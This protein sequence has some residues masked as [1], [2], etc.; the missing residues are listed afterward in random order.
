MKAGGARLHKSWDIITPGPCSSPYSC[1]PGYYASGEDS[2]W[3]FA[4][5]VGTQW[6]FGPVA[7]RLEYERVNVTGNEGGGD[8]D[9]LSA[10]VSWTFF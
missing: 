7:W 6:K 10:G 8:P 1:S 4:Y 5:G 3:D 9:M 2:N